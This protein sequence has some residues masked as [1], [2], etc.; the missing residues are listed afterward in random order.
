MDL[1]SATMLALLA[2]IPAA[3][4][5]WWWLW[6]ARRLHRAAVGAQVEGD[7]RGE[8]LS[9][10]LLLVALALIALGAARPLWD[11]GEVSLGRSDFSLIVALDVSLSMSAEDVDSGREPPVSRFAA[12]QSEIRRLID[13]RRGD[14]VGLVIFAG[15]AFLRFPLTRDHEAATEVLDALQPGEALV[16]PGSDIASAIDLA[17]TTISRASIAARGDQTHGAIAVV[18]DGET[19]GGDAVAAARAA[20]DLG[21][22]IYSV[23]VGSER[24]ASISLPP[25]GEPMIDAR[26]GA[27]VV[28]SLDRGHLD[29]IASIGGGRLITIDAPGAISRINADLAALD[30]VRE[31]IVE[32][33]A[34]AE[35]FQWFAGAA[36]LTLLASVAARVFGWSPGVRWEVLS[37]ATL[38]GSLLV[39][40]GCA[41]TGIEQANR[42]GVIHYEAGEFAEALADWREAQRLARRVNDDVDPRL[43]LNAG[44]ALHQLGQYDRAETETLNALRSDDAALS[45]IAWFHVGN[46]RWADDDLLGARAA[47]IEALRVQP[48]LRD[49]KLNLEIVNATLASLQE[50]AASNPD[51]QSRQ[52]GLG[53]SAQSATGGSDQ[54]VPSNAKSDV[55]EGAPRARDD[56]ARGAPRSLPN[57]GIGSDGNAGPTAPTFRE[58][59]SMQARREQTLQDLQMAL[60]DL[61]LENASLEQALA[62]L[63]ALRA[64]PGERLAAGRLDRSSGILDW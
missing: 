59:M 6:R 64:V 42:E 5:A 40:G 37:L 35:R 52:P 4:I 55:A 57:Q 30:L 24:G 20:H 47:F 28:T 33:T 50:N 8:R 62:V 26:S 21:L 46:H 61:P 49:A 38:A 14:R 12:A 45:A 51:I 41:A 16:Q 11:D 22:R 15:D 25:A 18:S 60:D 58:D 39:V 13:S 2:L 36:A 31:L 54:A 34:L 3:G 56:S 10:L 23:G 48:S 53:A 7:R 9:R 32:D 19:H 1:G 17:A 29:R 27:P 43:H 63:D 44:R